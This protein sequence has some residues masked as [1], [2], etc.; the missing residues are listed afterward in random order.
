MRLPARILRSLAT[1]RAC[2]EGA[3]ILEFALVLPI[4]VA[5]TAGCFELGRALIVYRQL[6]EAARMLA[7]EPDPTCRPACAPGVAR[8]LASA[9]DQ[10]AGN[11]MRPG[12]SVAAAVVEAPPSGMVGLRMEMQ[13]QADLLG[14]VGLV[15]LGPLLRFDVVRYEARLG[16]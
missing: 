5:L 12:R 10:V 16:A 3:A 15:G 9:A 8:I 13:L 6:G 2:R 14:L 7:R 11:A 4:L 1:L